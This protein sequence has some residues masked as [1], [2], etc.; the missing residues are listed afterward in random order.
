[1]KLGLS[2]VAQEQ[3]PLSCLARTRVLFNS[4][5]QHSRISANSSGMTEVF[6]VAILI[7]ILGDRIGLMNIVLKT[8][9]ETLGKY[10]SS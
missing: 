10:E 8:G 9:Q 4:A 5:Q 1:M 2:P 7:A 3:L 6:L